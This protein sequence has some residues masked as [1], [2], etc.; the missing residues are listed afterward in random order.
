M[1]TICCHCRRAMKI[2]ASAAWRR[3]SP[4]LVA[5][6]EAEGCSHAYC[7]DCLPAAKAEIER[8]REEIATCP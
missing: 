8:L 1:K 6:Y 2:H 5:H 4:E 3:V 7:P